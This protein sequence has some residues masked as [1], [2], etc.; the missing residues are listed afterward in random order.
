MTLSTGRDLGLVVIGDGQVALVADGPLDEALVYRRSQTGNALLTAI[1][2]ARL[3]LEVALVTRL[4]SDAFTP[5]L[6]QSW[7]AEYL[8]LD[9]ARQVAG[10]NAVALVGADADGRQEQVYREGAAAT[11]DVDDVAPVPWELTRYV[12]APGA[13]SAL[14]PRPHEAVRSAF[15]AARSKGAV[16]IHDPT[17]R[18]GLWPEDAESRAKEAFDDLLPLTDILVIGAP[19]ATGRLLARATAEEAA[20]AAQRRGVPRVVVRLGGQRGCLVVDR[21]E[22]T[23]IPGVEPPEVR[24][25]GWG[26]EAAFTAGLVAGLVRGQSLAEAAATALETTALAVAAGAD[27]DAMPWLDQLNRFRARRGGEPLA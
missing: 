18:S 14:G 2:G 16:T 12:Y 19:F 21:D 13:T 11:L 8:H 7:E 10:R 17:L 25:S 26:A 15:A 3:G 4:G 27:L 1:G 6:L 22:V 24:R 23:Q 20:Q 5:W 9:Y